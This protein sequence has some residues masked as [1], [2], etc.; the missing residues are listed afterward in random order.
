MPQAKSKKRSI[1]GD[2]SLYQECGPNHG[3]PPVEDGPLSPRT[4][5]PTRVRPDHK[6]KAPWVGAFSH[7]YTEKGAPRRF[8]VKAATE[9][10]ARTRMRKRMGQVQEAGGAAASTKTTV[11]KWSEEW[12]AIVVQTYRPQSYISARS[13]VQK[14]IVPAIGHKRL[15]ELAPADVRKVMNRMREAGMKV[16]TRRRAHSV[17]MVML[18]A[19]Q[20][21]GHV[22][23]SLVLKVKAPPPTKAHR[24]DLP[25]DLAVEMLVVASE[26]PDASR[27]VAALM[28]GIRQGESLGLTWPQIDFD[29]HIVVIAQQLKPLPYNLPYDR[30][31]GFRVPDDYEA[32]QIKDRWH[33][34]QPKTEDSYRVLPMLPWFEKSLLAWREKVPE[35]KH[36]LVWPADDG[37]PRDPKH[38]DA[39]WYELQDEVGR[40]RGQDVLYYGDPDFPDGRHYGIHEARH[41]TATL[42]LEAG[43]DPAIITAILGHSTMLSTKAYLHVKTAPIAAALEKVAERLQLAA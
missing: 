1:Y 19:A 30:S 34:V 32:V 27:W 29:R 8:K 4:G 24:T 25:I 17:L 18:T 5:K 3:C 7:G 31:S 36:Q 35:S 42:L 6:C 14:W 28:E 38:D 10:Q 16:S 21:D 11:K 15:T 40:R 20:E 12:L 39:A 26:Q 22:I 23:P 41:T 2:G 43:V 33:L 9:A 13:A 37:G